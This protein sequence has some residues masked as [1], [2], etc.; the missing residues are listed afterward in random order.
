[1][2][3]AKAGRLG[4][5]PR[6]ASSTGGPARERARTGAAGRPP[7][8][9]RTDEQTYARRPIGV[10]SMRAPGAC[11]RASANVP[12]NASVVARR[13]LGGGCTVVG[14]AGGTLG[15]QRGQ[16]R[17]FARP[18]RQRE[19]GEICGVAAAH[20][21]S[22]STCGHR[23]LLGLSVFALTAVSRS[24]SPD[25][26]TH[27]HQ[28]GGTRV[29]ARGRPAGDSAQFQGR[30]AVDR[31]APR[32]PVA[33]RSPSERV[34]ERAPRPDG[35]ASWPDRQRTAHSNADAQ[36]DRA[37]PTPTAA[38]AP[39]VRDGHR[40]SRQRT[41]HPAVSSRRLRWSEPGGAEQRSHEHHGEYAL[42]AEH[43]ASRLPGWKLLPLQPRAMRCPESKR[44]LRSP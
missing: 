2:H 3:G 16:H 18:V 43:H 44:R 25:A 11:V 33:R 32:S 29:R 41:D 14:V 1:M 9:R 7:R 21:D 8:A 36:L 39:A 13:N 40:L 20:K 35:L 28:R 4:H 5:S 23:L 22:D 30:A 31:R 27:V 15:S 17:C 42:A 34:Q 26:R 19:A 24:A 10:G 37:H 6:L 12:G 38:R